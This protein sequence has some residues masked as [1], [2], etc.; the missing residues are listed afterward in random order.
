M[1]GLRVACKVTAGLLTGGPA[2]LA[3]LAGLWGNL[4]FRVHL[5]LVGLLAL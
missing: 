2:G 5:L 1:S 3:G 4:P